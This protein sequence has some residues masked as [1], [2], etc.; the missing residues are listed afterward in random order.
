MLFNNTGAGGAQGPLASAGMMM[1][2]DPS[3]VMPLS[4]Y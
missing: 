2:E 1:F 4:K 3:K